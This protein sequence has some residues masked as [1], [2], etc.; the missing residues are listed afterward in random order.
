[1]KSHQFSHSCICV[2][3]EMLENKVATDHERSFETEE[4]CDLSIFHSLNIFRLSWNPRTFQ[5]NHQDVNS[6]ATTMNFNGIS[7]LKLGINYCSSLTLEEFL[8]SVCIVT[9]VHVICYMIGY[10]SQVT[11]VTSP[12]PPWSRS[13]IDNI[14]SIQ[15]L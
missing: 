4:N 13:E 11:H 3:G 9:F 10:P 6:S 8:N 14:Y 5:G 15:M 1:M 2:K 12:M 7:L